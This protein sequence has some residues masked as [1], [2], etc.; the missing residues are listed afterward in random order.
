MVHALTGNSGLENK[1]IAIL[2]AGN[3]GESMIKCLQQSG[4]HNIIATRTKEAELDRLAETYGI[5][6]AYDNKYAA[7]N[8]D[9]VI[10]SVKPKDL[11][12]VISEIRM[13][14]N[15]KLYISTVAG[16]SID[17]LSQELGTD[18]VIRTMPNLGLR[19]GIG[20]TAYSL[21]TGCTEK[22]K[23]T[24][25]AIF[26]AGGAVFEV[27]ENKMVP[28]T[29]AA[30]MLGWMANILGT[31]QNALESMS[32]GQREIRSL[33][34]STLKTLLH[35]TE[36]CID[37]SGFHDA[38]ASKGGG[39][40]AGTLYAESRDLAGTLHEMSYVAYRKFLG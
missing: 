19:Y 11:A 9:I 26:G 39:T 17:Y 35:I 18:R 4:C 20:A 27:K 1:T 38:V 16:K 31:Y 12:Q 28:V 23:E 6:T 7:D 10:L 36:D 8:A 3:I 13:P 2:G 37:Y 21:G 34:S 14:R 25:E 32:L 24:V 33:F 5:E 40:E 22:D 29:V 15:D 30:C